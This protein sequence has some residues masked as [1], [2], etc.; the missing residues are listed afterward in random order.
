[1]AATNRSYIIHPALLRP[2]RFYKILYIPLPDKKTRYSI[3]EMSAKNKPLSK[4]VDLEKI[5]ELS[6]GFSGAEI[7]SVVNVAI[8]FVL[9]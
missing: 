7:T 4:D 3:L 1:M 9:Q 2:G 8:S 6:E 5:A